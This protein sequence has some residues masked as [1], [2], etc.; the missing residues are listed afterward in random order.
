MIV[1]KVIGRVW[2]TAK[3]PNLTGFKFLLVQDFND[4]DSK[5]AIVVVDLVDAGVSDMVLVVHEGGSARQCMGAPD[6]PVNAAA[7]ALVDSVNGYANE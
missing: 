6:A 2:S 1:G 5:R 3:E 4:V 7:V